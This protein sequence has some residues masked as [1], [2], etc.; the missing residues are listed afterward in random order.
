M[1]LYI[2]QRLYPNP[3]FMMSLTIRTQSCT[4]EMWCFV[5][6]SLMLLQCPPKTSNCCFYISLIVH[7][8]KKKQK[9]KNNKN[10]QHIN[11]WASELLVGVFFMFG[12]SAIWVEMPSSNGLRVSWQLNTSI[13]L[14]KTA[15]KNII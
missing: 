15:F 12:L 11:Y 14:W 13:V 1:F 8:L 2:V 10:I 5:C 7:K 3:C 6:S 4:Y 9:N